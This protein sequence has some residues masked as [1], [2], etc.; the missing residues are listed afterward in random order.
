MAEVVQLAEQTLQI[1][2]RKWSWTPARPDDE[3]KPTINPVSQSVAYI[4]NINA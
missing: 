4:N 3:A 2:I 1:G